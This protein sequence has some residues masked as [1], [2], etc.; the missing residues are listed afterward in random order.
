MSQNLG[1]NCIRNL[2]R[3]LIKHSPFLWFC[4]LCTYCYKMGFRVWSSS[5]DHQTAII[6]CMGKTLYFL[7]LLYQNANMKTEIIHQRIV[8]LEGTLE[9]CSPTYCPISPFC[10]ELHHK[11]PSPVSCCLWLGCL[12]ESQDWL[13]TSPCLELQLVT[14]ANLTL[15]WWQHCL[16]WGHLVCAHHGAASFFLC[17]PVQQYLRGGYW[18]ETQLFLK[19]QTAGGWE[20]MVID[21]NR[22]CSAWW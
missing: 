20:A 17:S 9:V 10:P 7:V 22:R 6:Q 16:C 1:L 8:E 12:G 5:S 3:E 21:W 15:L 13:V 14:V 19:Q 11:T 2:M 4:S 18:E